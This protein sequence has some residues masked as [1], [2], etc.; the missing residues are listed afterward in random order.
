[1]KKWQFWL[2]NALAGAILMLVFVN[3]SLFLGN[4]SVQTIVLQQQQY[5]NDSI[6]LSRVNTQ[7]IRALA[8]VSAQTSDEEI[9]NVLAEHG[10]TFSFTPDAAQT[11]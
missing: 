11:E 9:R 3:I 1:M 8:L 10:V 6:R 7:L 5:I 2:L 4:R